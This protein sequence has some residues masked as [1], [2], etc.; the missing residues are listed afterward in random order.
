[1]YWCFATRLHMV[2]RVSGTGWSDSTQIDNRYYWESV[3]KQSS[4]RIILPDLILTGHVELQTEKFV[5]HQLLF[6]FP[7]HFIYE[8]PHNTPKNPRHRYIFDKKILI[9]ELVSFRIEEVKFCQKFTFSKNLHASSSPQIPPF[10][11]LHPNK[12]V[13]CL[14]DFN[15]WIF[16]RCSISQRKRSR[17]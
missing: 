5:I 9:R 13:I 12:V 1:L 15:C 7:L 16:W 2:G 6:L 14:S 10:I 17:L 8:K 11:F 4:Y 3:N